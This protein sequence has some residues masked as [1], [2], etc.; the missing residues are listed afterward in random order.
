M[1][2]YFV[3]FS[4]VV[5]EFYTN[6]RAY[7]FYL[8]S[9]IYFLVVCVGRCVEINTSDMPSSISPT[10]KLSRNVSNLQKEGVTD[11]VKAKH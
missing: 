8:A 5:Q 7:C 10:C 3:M 11:Q 1:T 2:F 9:C 6:S 4:L